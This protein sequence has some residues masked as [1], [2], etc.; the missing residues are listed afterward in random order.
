M[1]WQLH[2]DGSFDLTGG[3]V[4]LRGCYPALDGAAVRPL[5]V[6]VGR[7][8]RNV[9]GPAGA[10]VAESAWQLAGLGGPV[11]LWTAALQLLV[12]FGAGD[13]RAR[14][15]M[16]A[17][18]YPQWFACTL[19]L[20][21]GLSP[22]L[23]LDGVPVDPGGVVGASVYRV[24]G[25]WFGPK[26]ALVVLG[27]GWMASLPMSLGFL[28]SRVW[29]ALVPRRKVPP[30][31]EAVPRPIP[32]WDACLG[33]LGGGTP[34]E[35]CVDEPRGLTELKESLE[36][37]L[38]EFGLGVT[39]T[40]PRRGPV[41]DTF[42][43]K[44]DPGVKVARL[45]ALQDDLSIGV[46]NLRIALGA[47]SLTAEVPRTRR[48]RVRLGKVLGSGKRDMETMEIPLALGVTPLGLPMVV[49]LTSLPHLLVAGATGSG[50][51]T[52][53]ASLLCGLL[54]AKSPEALELVLVDPKRLEFSPFGKVP[55]L[56]RPVVTEPEEAVEVLL[57]TVQEMERRYRLLQGA[58]ARNLRDY[59]RESA[60][61]LP[62]RL[63][64]V[65][66]LADLLLTEKAAGDALLRLAQKARACGIHLLLATQRPS[67]DVLTGVI[68]ANFPAR[69][70][71]QVASS[72]DSKTILDGMGAERL[73][74]HGDFLFARPGDSPRRGHGPYVSSEEVDRLAA[75]MVHT[76]GTRRL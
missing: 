8:T 30:A 70:A 18:G 75:H 24:L 9:L 56:L 66:E 38:G 25:E 68:K 27:F 32:H 2:Q 4:N 34:P 15:A 60:A 6:T 14:L 59:N 39:L 17:L 42:T 58:G 51:S 50:K 7:P 63:V 53:L 57:G 1:Q 71:Y 43:C 3:P 40:Q 47:G 16:W 41:V 76:L 11:F 54:V 67:V 20:F 13:R 23:V 65:D 29:G 74:G 33:L 35:D 62:Y 21:S 73:L 36:H 26:G 64:V 52:G 44:L 69:L 55:H 19:G 46:G 49:D 10:A 5:H 22:A 48:E 72:H 45:L 12:L 28:P 31:Q 61:P 37:R